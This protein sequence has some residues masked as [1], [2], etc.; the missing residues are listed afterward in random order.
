MY[1][2]IVAATGKTSVQ[3]TQLLLHRLEQAVLQLE[4]EA[5]NH[6]FP[7]ATHG[8]TA[9]WGNHSRLLNL[10]DYFEEQLHLASQHLGAKQST[11]R[12]AHFRTCEDRRNRQ[13]EECGLRRDVVDLAPCFHLVC[14]G[15][16]PRHTRCTSPYIS[17]G[18]V[19]ERSFNG[20]AISLLDEISRE[21]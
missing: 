17:T 16:S 18:T 11:L 10:S 3:R 7:E 1:I 19:E 21:V 2:L 15:C 8:R 5:R 20:R 13:C 6:L 9:L 12:A 4:W 14:R